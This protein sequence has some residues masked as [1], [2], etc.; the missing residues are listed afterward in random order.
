MSFSSSHSIAFA[1]WVISKLPM[2]ISDDFVE[3]IGQT[4][5][6]EFLLSDEF[7]VVSKQNIDAI[8][9]L[10][11]EGIPTKPTKSNKPTK[12]RKPTKIRSDAQ[13]STDEQ[14]NDETNHIVI[15]VAA[16]TTQPK[17]KKPRANKK[18]QIIDDATAIPE[19]V[20]ASDATAIP[21]VVNASDA[22]AEPVSDAVA[23]TTQPKTK[24][25][26][27]NKKQQIIDDATAIPEV[28]NAS[29]AAAKPESD[30][31]VAVTTQPN[32]KKPRVTKPKKQQIVADKYGETNEIE[33][34]IDL[35]L[36][37]HNLNISDNDDVVIPEQEQI[38][39]QH[40]RTDAAD[41][42]DKDNNDELI[43]EAYSDNDDDDENE[44]QLTEYFVNGVLF[45]ADE[46]GNWFDQNIQSVENPTI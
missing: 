26:R 33:N 31:A 41:I 12:P 1:K 9:P 6:D 10:L 44:Q 24:K 5:W 27:A 34:E 13:T 18:L 30:A 8:I 14:D 43:E 40:S 16:V 45:Y 15:Q 7:Q 28:V 29:D 17:P 2:P 37:F 22:D 42:M 19:V 23:V 36:N 25:P 3:N 4:L 35:N 46:H 20:N 32:I 11:V 21:E 39:L 38:Q